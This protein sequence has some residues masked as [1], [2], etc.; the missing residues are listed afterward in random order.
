VTQATNT[1]PT[2]TRAVRVVLVE[3]DPVDRRFSTVAIEVAGL[4]GDLTS[5]ATAETALTHLDEAVRAGAGVPDLVIVDVDLPTMSGLDL[6]G[7]LRG[8]PELCHIPVVVLSSWDDAAAELAATAQGA[9]AYVVK[10]LRLEDLSD[11]LR[12]VGDRLLGD[13]A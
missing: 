1:A 6:L 12:A 13:R 8:R 4:G 2:A 5:F 7:H 11:S 3:D 9:R 10:P